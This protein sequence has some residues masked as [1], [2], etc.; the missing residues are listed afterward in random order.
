MGIPGFN[1]FVNQFGVV[2]DITTLRGKTIAIDGHI[3]LFETVRGPQSNGKT[4]TTT[5]FKRIL[6]LQKLEIEPIVIFDALTAE[7]P[8]P[9]I[10]N[11]CIKRTKRA[12]GKV[13]NVHTFSNLSAKIGAVTNLLKAMG[14]RV[15]NAKEDGEAQCAQLEQAGLVQGCVTLD[16]DYFLYGGEN[17]YK[18][19]FAKALPVVT[20]FAFSRVCAAGQGANIKI[21]TRNR[22]IAM[23][24]LVGNDYYERGIEKIGFISALEI[25][26]EFSMHPDD[27]PSTILDRFRSYS[28]REIPERKNDTDVK[29]KLRTK[30]F[31]DAFP[32]GFP[33]SDGFLACS[34]IFLLP[35][36]LLYDGKDFPLPDRPNFDKPRLHELIVQ[37][38]GWVASRF[39]K[40]LS[41]TIPKQKEGSK[42]TRFYPGRRS[43]SRSANNKAHVNGNGAPVEEDEDEIVACSSKEWSHRQ[44]VAV[45][46][47]RK[48]WLEYSD[49]SVAQQNDLLKSIESEPSSI[50][51]RA[52][53]PETAG[54][55]V[56]KKKP[57]VR[58]LMPTKNT[59]DT[60]NSGVSGDKP[61]LFHE[62]NK[63]KRG[64]PRN[65][66]SLSNDKNRATAATGSGGATAGT[67]EVLNK[68]EFAI[69]TVN[70]D[71]N[72]L[73]Q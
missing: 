13:W 39:E 33:N 69:D 14:V 53:A 8:P 73:S 44:W 40:E 35:D 22:L 62:T 11:K 2:V 25:I 61:I 23:A 10:P 17:L 43:G 52:I 45:D 70:V 51:K 28:T 20:H 6:T 67:N 24:I 46:R 59:D 57:N 68:S 64:F 15:I 1:D 36:V 27:H 4:Y 63:R 65:T 32:D 38:G 47:L 26:S 66:I 55:E 42:I 18:I 29:V 58:V 30:F 9:A 49:L 7:F 5:F 3:W 31:V 37:E 12:G 21:L 48:S 41:M 72:L 19:D 50:R 60:M 54:S 34:N 71:S 16:Y 56:G